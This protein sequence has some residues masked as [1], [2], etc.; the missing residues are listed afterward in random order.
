MPRCCPS[1]SCPPFSPGSVWH[2]S[3]IRVTAPHN[4][5]PPLSFPSSIVPSSETQAGTASPAILSSPKAQYLPCAADKQPNT[6]VMNKSQY[7]TYT[8]TPARGGGPF[9]WCIFRL[10]WRILNPIW[11]T[12][13]RCTIWLRFR[14]HCW[15]EQRLCRSFLECYPHRKTLDKAKYYSL[16]SYF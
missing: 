12:V 13:S 7:S 2:L 15:L 4:P 6:E 11:R 10:S 14:D 3:F 1:E 16:M 8:H 9:I 5:A